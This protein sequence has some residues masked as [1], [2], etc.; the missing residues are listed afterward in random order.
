MDRGAWQITVHRVAESGT[1]EHAH[2]LS[3]FCPCIT[4]LNLLFFI[5]WLTSICY[6]YFV[7]QIVLVLAIGSSFLF[8]SAPFNILSSEGVV[9]F[10]KSVLTF[11]LSFLNNPNPHRS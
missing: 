11:L 9:L 4:L 8:P 2:M 3:S 5:L 7:A 10:L 6:F 1:I